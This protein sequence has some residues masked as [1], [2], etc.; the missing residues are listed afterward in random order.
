MGHVVTGNGVQTDP[1]KVKVISDIQ[2]ANLMEADGI[3]P[4]QKKIRSFLG[5]ILYYQHFIIDCSAK[6]KTS[7]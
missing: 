6:A 7:F 2:T 1:E 5:M 4:S 3:T